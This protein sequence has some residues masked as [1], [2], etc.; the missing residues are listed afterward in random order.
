[1][2][3]KGTWQILQVDDD[4]EDYIITRQMLNKT[5]GHPAE[6]DWAPGFE[7]G[8]QKL[9]SQ[10]YDAVL[11]DY[12]LGQRS[13]IELIQ[14]LTS[15][16]YAAPLILLTGRG[17]YDVDVEAM[18]A[19][20]ALYLSK[21]ETT[22]LQLE[23]S[24]RYAIE[25]QQMEQALRQSEEKFAQAF[26][27]N[28]AAMALVCLKDQRVMD[29]NVAWLSMLGY[30]RDEVVGSPLTHN[31][32]LPAEDLAVLTQELM[33]KGA[34]HNREQV[35][36]KR[37]GERF[38]ALGSAVI[39]HGTGEPVVLS[40]WLNMNER[41]RV[42]DSREEREAYF[43][44]LVGNIAQLAWMADETGWIYWYNQPWYDYT[45]LSLAETQGWGWQKAHHPQHVGRV[46]EKFKA[47][48]RS[49]Q[50][51]ED[52]FPLR[53]KD[54]QY[55]WFLSLGKPIRD[56]H[57]KIIRWV[58]TD[59][60][61]TRQREVE[62]ALRATETQLRDSEARLQANVRELEAILDAVPAYMWITHDP[63]AR[64]MTG[65]H[66]A[67]ELVHMLPGE[68]ISRTGPEPEKI[69]R[70]VAL[71]DG[72]VIP[73]EELP[74]Q[75]VAISGVPLRDYEFDVLL[76][77]GALL[78]LLGNVA[79]LL[80]EQGR[81]AGAISAF[82]DITDLKQA[83]E[84]LGHYA[85]E[86]ERSNQALQ[87]F[88]FIASHDLQEPLRKIIL[89]GN[90]LRRRLSEPAG[91]AAA[92]EP[93]VDY[94]ER[95]QRAAERMQKMIDGLLD[96]SRV[97]TRGREF[98]PVDLNRVAREVVSDLE[99]RLR[100]TQGRVSV[101]DL[102]GVLGDELQLR[103]L[104]Q[105]LIGNALKFHREG[106]APQVQVTGEQ[107]GKGKKQVVHLR[108]ADNGI[109]FEAEQAERIFQPFV[110]L[111]GSTAYDGSGIGLAICQKIVERHGGRIR[112][113]SQPG[114][115][116]TFSVELPLKP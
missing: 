28:P 52:T 74:V 2:V 115:G 108:V 38:M 31:P 35:L 107:V 86:L 61:V 98:E 18:H 45:G 40:T 54:G 109:G 110:R 6:L 83:E 66:M 85:R 90:S 70:F 56:E 105:N 89:F 17:G 39:I 13:G 20:A 62:A 91:E 60:D 73:D 87:D 100:A 71:R 42:E 113:S 103:Q 97:N 95:M 29:V 55:R 14:Q 88:A 57:G 36:V 27:I 44:H 99:A 94:L 37:S 82:I 77:D 75:Q 111:H 81:P 10:S 19:G 80:D 63:Q 114:S 59:T 8:L 11:V 104:L 96:L 101:G 33:E 68:N 21:G 69:P 112:V 24:L 46:T 32:W 102:P 47:C 43:H 51:W 1:M 79:P 41:K 67:A 34:I 84:N 25:Q 16:G 12:D 53:G 15:Q 78:N 49:G 65:N 9:H 76:E 50:P 92:D 48:L 72:Q 106:V 64:E 93:A 26:A 7:Q 58:G 22:P 4:E 3:R 23:R 30:S 5:N 116:S